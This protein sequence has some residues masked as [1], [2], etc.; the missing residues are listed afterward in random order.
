MCLGLLA[1][2]VGYADT[3]PPQSTPVAATT[4]ALPPSSDAVKHA[5]RTACVKDAKTKK[6]VGPDKTSYIKNCMAAP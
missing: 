3:P 1:L 6:L 2:T 4:P 5:K